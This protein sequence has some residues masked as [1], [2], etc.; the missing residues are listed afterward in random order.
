MLKYYLKITL[1]NNTGVKMNLHALSHVYVKS[2]F[3][4]V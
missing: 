2:E 3:T 1:T 4:T